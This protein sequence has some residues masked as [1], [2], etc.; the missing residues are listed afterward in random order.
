MINNTH[1]LL[2]LQQ[3]ITDGIRITQFTKSDVMLWRKEMNHME[4]K[5][6]RLVVDDEQALYSSFSAEDEFSESVK[7]YI[8]SKAAS[9]DIRQSISLTVIARK[10]IDEGRF[11]SSVAN[12]ISGEKAFFSKNEKDTSRMLIGE[13]VFGSIMII[14]SLTLQ[15]QFEVLQYSLLPI[16]GSLALSSAAKTLIMELPM[17]LAKKRML[18]ELESE[19]VITFEYDHDIH[20]LK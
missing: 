19:S 5:N 1:N 17:N 18:K 8:R 6:I 15:K 14:L 4:P 2:A 20:P 12:W 3:L 11:R 9:K 7:S 13:L 16:M 10:P